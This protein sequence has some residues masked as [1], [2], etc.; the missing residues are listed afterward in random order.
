MD[1]KCYVEAS[2][3]GNLWSLPFPIHEITQTAVR[4]PYSSPVI[5][6]NNDNIRN[7][8]NNNNLN[9][10]NLIPNR[11]S[12]LGNYNYKRQRSR[13]SSTHS[14]SSTGSSNDFINNES[15]LIV[16][17]QVKRIG[18]TKVVTFRDERRD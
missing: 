9:P 13:H 4:I 12:L 10:N 7:N 15:I 5:T 18:S 17:V 6:N 16:R 1:P 2:M 3:D 11:S 14:S 8:N